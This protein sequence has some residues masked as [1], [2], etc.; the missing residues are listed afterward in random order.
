MEA[1]AR[2]GERGALRRLV[3]RALADMTRQGADVALAWCLPHS[4]SY[5]VLLAAG[6]VPFP[7]RYRPIELH[8]GVRAFDASLARTVADRNR[9]YLSYL[10]SDTV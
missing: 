1:L 9:W 8:A 6:F 4:P 2:P 7:E 3:S 5:R 10:D